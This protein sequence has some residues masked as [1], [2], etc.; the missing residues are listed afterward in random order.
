M[1]ATVFQSDSLPATHRPG[2]AVLG[3]ASAAGV[4][5]AFLV[6]AGVL[7]FGFPVLILLTWLASRQVAR[8][9][10]IQPTL[11]SQRLWIPILAFSCMLAVRDAAAIRFLNLCMVG[12]FAGI[13]AI[14]SRPGILSKGT[15]FDYPLRAFA[16]WAVA[17]VDAVVLLANDIAWRVIPQNSHG[18]QLGAVLRGLL[19]A[20][21][22]LIVFGA[23]FASADA[24]FESMLTGIS[25][26]AE[27]VTEQLVIGVAC[28]WLTAGF[29]RRMFIGNPPPIQTGTEPKPAANRIGSM[30]LTIVLGSLNL[31][32]IAFVATQFRYFFGG[33]EVVRSTAD[34]AVADFARRGF[35]EL[36]AVTGLALP[37]LL[38]LHAL[39]DPESPKMRRLYKGLA[40]VLVVLLTIVM[41]SAAMKMKL[42]MDAYN[43]TTLRLYVAATLVWL[44]IVFGWFAFTVLRD[45]ESRFAWGGV[46]TLAAA[47]FGL[48]LLN[49]DGFVA[50]WNLAHSDARKVDW[51][52]LEGLSADAAPELIGAS[53]ARGNEIRER[54]RRRLAGTDWRSMNLSLIIAS[55]SRV[56]NR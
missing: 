49:P 5:A 43:M 9:S 53:A 48:N 30:E 15:V 20:T 40:A 33:A 11:E 45:R 38:G 27:T 10:L 1:A 56:R 16:A 29:L 2:L 24:G 3:A 50:S 36:V 32:F 21:P 23:L 4:A 19:L 42:Y 6:P 26:D 51:S 34:L 41:L 35:F 39:I 25:F 47:I 22:L 8:A 17:V 28:T 13:L 44:A 18:R 54:H 12:L 14:R 46:V 52:Y 37:T 55:Q 7:G 31:L